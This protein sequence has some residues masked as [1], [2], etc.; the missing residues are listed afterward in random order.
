[1]RL[2]IERGADPFMARQGMTPRTY[3]RGNGHTALAEYLLKAEQAWTIKTLG[4]V[5][6]PVADTAP[7][8]KKFNIAVMELQ[9]NALPA[10]DLDGLSNR[11]RADLF[12]TGVF[13]VLERSA[14]EE[15]LREQGFQQSGCVSSECAVQAGQLIGVEKMVVGSVDKLGTA[16]SV[17]LRMVDVA[18]GRIERTAT[19]DCNG[20]GIERVLTESIRSAARVVAGLEKQA[21]AAAPVPDSAA[22]SGSWR[23]LNT[24]PSLGGKTGEVCLE[25]AVSQDRVSGWLLNCA[26]RGDPRAITGTV[27]GSSIRLRLDQKMLTTQLTLDWEGELRDNRISGT[28]VQ[29]TS[30]G[31]ENSGTWVVSRTK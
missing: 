30:R 16:Y 20:C 26:G 13:T 15:I 19:A 11:L 1:V 22:W 17:A 10:G 3:A 18:T 31:S 24:Y 28:F 29:R 8:V 6:K 27:S 7:P 14:M 25:L 4:K 23:G 12:N 21:G 5:E 2:L 9:S